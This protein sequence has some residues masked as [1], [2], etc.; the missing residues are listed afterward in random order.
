M[1]QKCFNLFNDHQNSYTNVTHTSKTCKFDSN[2]KHGI[3][4]LISITLS[5]ENPCGLL[6]RNQR[7]QSAGPG[8]ESRCE[9]LFFACSLF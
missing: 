6:E 2:A 5:H 7:Y 8:F 3:G 9:R 1:Y 4:I